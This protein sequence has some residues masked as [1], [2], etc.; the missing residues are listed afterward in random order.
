MAP[1]TPQP[2]L[3]RTV[4]ALVQAAAGGRADLEWL[5]KA[6]RK[7]GYVPGADCLLPA[8]LRAASA[9]IVRVLAD[10]EAAAENPC[11]RRGLT[12]ALE[13]LR[14]AVSKTQAVSRR[15]PGGPR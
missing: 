6:I 4:A 10:A 7:A 11:C 3:R 5:D 2:A 13:A 15:R 14:A 9:S 1:R 12:H 8:D